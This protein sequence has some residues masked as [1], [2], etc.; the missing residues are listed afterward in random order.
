V[1]L[2]DTVIAVAP[3]PIVKVPATAP[4]AVVPGLKAIVI[5]QFA[6]VASE[7]VQVVV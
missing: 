6:L 4:D 1:P 7:P 3:V 5:V 2:R